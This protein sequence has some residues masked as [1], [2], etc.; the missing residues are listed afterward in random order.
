MLWPQTACNLTLGAM[1][2]CLDPLQHAPT[3]LREAPS[4]GA[5]GRPG[6]PDLGAQLLKSRGYGPSPKPHVAG[7]SA[8]EVLDLPPQCD[9]C[10]LY[11]R[12]LKP[13]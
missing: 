8:V 11:I 4:A 12:L 2:W 6:R 5:S 9:M 1:Y 10:M 7:C 13:C 3:T